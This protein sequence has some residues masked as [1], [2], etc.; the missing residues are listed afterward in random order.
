[1]FYCKDA[2]EGLETMD[3]LID[4]QRK[5]GQLLARDPPGGRPGD[6]P[7]RSQ[8]PEHRKSEARSSSAARAASSLPLKL[9]PA[10][11]QARC[12]WKMVFKHLNINEL[13]RLSWGAKNAHGQEWEKLQAGVRRPAGADDTARPCAK[14]G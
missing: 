6:G 8:V 13:Y 3:Q 14:A 12:R 9:G 5:R 11:G 7:R 2:F 4:P 10:A 1:M